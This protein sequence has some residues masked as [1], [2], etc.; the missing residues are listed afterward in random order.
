MRD[1]YIPL[2]TSV[3]R[4]SLWSESGDCIKVFLTLCAEADCDGFVRASPDGIRRLADLT[5]EDTMRHLTTLEAPEP[6]SKDI[7]R[8][9]K[10]DGRRI[11]RIPDGW[12][13][14]NLEWYRKEAQ[15]QAELFRKRKWWDQKGSG[16]RRDARRTDTETE[17]ETPDP[18]KD[19][20]PSI[21]SPKVKWTMVPEGWLPT[22]A[23][24]KRC[25][26]W[27]SGFYAR[28]L[29][30]FRSH[31]FAKPKTDANKTFTRWL[32]EAETRLKIPPPVH[33][34]KIGGNW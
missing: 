15:R 23:H 4:S 20:D 13:V 3:V 12:R 25:A 17:T 7:T 26:H 19:Q 33:G 24:R 8:D 30:K 18:K 2:F 31:T 34:P 16:A 14:V 11:E 27:P 10:H 5:L 21:G 28:E 32:A 29:E 22:D 6:M 9:P 1:P